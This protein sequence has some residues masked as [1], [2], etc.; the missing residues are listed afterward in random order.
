[1][2]AIGGVTPSPLAT[3]LGRTETDGPMSRIDPKQKDE[4]RQSSHPSA[5]KRTLAVGEAFFTRRLFGT[6]AQRRVRDDA[7]A[8]TSVGRSHTGWT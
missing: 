5:C 8:D 7:G 2:S 4:F 6:F 1:M 3:S